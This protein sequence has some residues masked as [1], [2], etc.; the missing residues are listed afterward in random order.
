MDTVKR[1]TNVEQLEEHMP[2]RAEG[3][4]ANLHYRM[5]GFY[6]GDSRNA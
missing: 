5:N 2:G 1:N 6:P 4:C 3:Y